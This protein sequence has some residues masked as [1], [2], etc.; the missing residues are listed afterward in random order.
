M[1]GSL[2]SIVLLVTLLIVR[3]ASAQTD[4]DS[5][6]RL[7]LLHQA[8]EASRANDHARA[9]D[10]A[11]RAGQIAMSISVRMFVAQEEVALG[12][13]ATAYA[14]AGL[15]VTESRRDTTSRNRDAVLAQCQ[16][17]VSRVETRLGHVTLQVPNPAPAGLHITVAGL[18]VN[19]AFFGAPY[20]VSPGNVAIHATA[21]DGTSFDATVAVAEGA[22]VAVPVSLAASAS[23]APNAANASQT[24]ES[25]SASRR[26]T[27]ESRPAPQPA[28]A[29]SGS[30]AVSPIPIVVAVVGVLGLVASAVLYGLSASDANSLENGG[31]CTL[32]YTPVYGYYCDPRYAARGRTCRVSTRARSSRSAWARAW[33]GLA[34]CGCSSVES[35]TRAITRR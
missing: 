9:L 7:N 6:A 30:A 8:E 32:V 3:S 13:L 15:C 1:H 22:T 24:P 29:H 4:M 12:Q 33:S 34:Q 14:D 35:A 18:P 26:R 25:R 2:G 20:I 28:T 5:G 16:L 23:T 11:R 19:A 31:H 27:A 21:D 17:I 10:L